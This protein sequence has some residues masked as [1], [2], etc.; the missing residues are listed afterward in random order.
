MVTGA[1][2]RN[3][4]KR[5]N[6]N[7]SNE[8]RIK[9]LSGEDI[10]LEKIYSRHKNGCLVG[11]E[12]FANSGKIAVVDSID[13]EKKVIRIA[14]PSQIYLEIAEYKFNDIH[15]DNYTLKNSFGLV[16]LDYYKYDELNEKLKKLN[17]N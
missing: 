7:Y 13:F 12:N 10:T 6:I 3:R 11:L 15:S 17:K 14:L 8:D 5:R 16:G 1:L 2:A 4:K 9:I